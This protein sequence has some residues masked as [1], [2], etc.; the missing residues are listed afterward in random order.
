MMA[1][2]MLGRNTAIETLSDVGGILR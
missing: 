2:M 1:R